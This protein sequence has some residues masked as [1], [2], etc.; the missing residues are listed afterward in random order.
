MG[1][2]ATE[3]RGG[4]PGALAACGAAAVPGAVPAGA[5]GAPAGP[6]AA[7]G[8]PRPPSSARSRQHEHRLE[9]RTDDDVERL[10]LAAKRHRRPA[11]RVA[12]QIG[13]DVVEARKL[14]D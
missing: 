8:A 7:G 2:I 9:I 1:S 5:P 14:L 3:P 4:G 13:E 10:L 11:L 12:L 6:A